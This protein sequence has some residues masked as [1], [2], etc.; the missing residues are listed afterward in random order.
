V[1]IFEK[2][3]SKKI[4]ALVDNSDRRPTIDTIAV[5]FRRDWA[6]HVLENALVSVRSVMSVFWLIDVNLEF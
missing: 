4:R 3:I 2:E 1:G 5:I 6:M